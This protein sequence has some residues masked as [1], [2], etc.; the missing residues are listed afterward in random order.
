VNLAKHVAFIAFERL[1]FNPL[2]IQW[3]EH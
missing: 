2:E 3:V 1:G